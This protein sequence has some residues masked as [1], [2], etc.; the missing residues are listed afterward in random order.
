[1]STTLLN[2]IFSGIDRFCKYVQARSEYEDNTGKEVG[3]VYSHE[4]AIDQHEEEEGGG[5]LQWQNG[6]SSY[7]V[8]LSSERFCGQKKGLYWLLIE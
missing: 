3:A 8:R 2:G 6:G 5:I 7:V 4:K 1:M